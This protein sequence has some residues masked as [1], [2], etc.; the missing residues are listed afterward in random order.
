M[1]TLAAMQARTCVVAGAAL[2]AVAVVLGAFAAHALKDTLVEAGQLDT[3][4]TG[5]RY[6]MWHALALIG[7]GLFRARRDGTWAPAWCFLFG[8]IAFSGSIY[9]L[10]FGILSSVMGPLTPLGGALLIAGWVVFAIQARSKSE[11]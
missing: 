8:S 9:C 5:V 4:H 3:W 7:Y 11:S 2:A 6:Q 1:L 10:S